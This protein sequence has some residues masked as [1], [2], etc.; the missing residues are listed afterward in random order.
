MVDRKNF[1]GKS[2]TQNF[3]LPF[4]STSIYQHA[5]QYSGVKLFNK[6]PT[7]L[8]ECVDNVKEFKSLLKT[9]L[10]THCFYSLDEFLCN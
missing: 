8:K 5:V 9:Y 6:L 10:T 1:E 4:A 7:D 3:H 2:T